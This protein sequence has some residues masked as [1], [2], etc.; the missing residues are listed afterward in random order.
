MEFDYKNIL[1]WGYGKSGRAVENVLKDINVP[2]KIY[3][4][5]IK[6]NGGN[7]I[8]KLSARV[9]KQFD[10]IVLSPAVSIYDKYVKL[11]EQLGV[12]VIGELEFG[13]WFTSADVIAVTGTN[14]KTTTVRLINEALKTAG[15]KSGAYGN[16]GEPLTN[17]YKVD[18]DYI[19]CEVSSFQLETTDR[20]APYVNVLLN[21]DKDHLDRHKTVENYIEIKKSLFK[22]CDNSDCVVLNM[23][24]KN[25]EKISREIAGS[26]TNFNTKNGFEIKNN[27]LYFKGEKTIKINE[28]LLNYT[29]TDNIL[30]VA[31]VLKSLNLDL[32]ILN[33]IELNEPCVPHR[34]EVFKK[35]NGVTYID[36]SKATNPH[37]M[38]KAVET[39]NGN[40]VLLLGGLNKG[41]N[42]NE[43]ISKLPNNV[44]KIITFGKSGKKISKICKKYNIVNYNVKWLH[45]VKNIL[46]NVINIGD[47]VLFSPA[48]ASFD[49]FN[50]YDKRGEYFKKIVNEMVGD[51]E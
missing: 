16:I 11:A 4:K 17:A 32:E 41:F 33:K 46:H 23:A 3:D 34:L 37:A 36:D 1:I 24:D 26:Q 30:A 14:G 9:L 28:R 18:L 31:C 12:K 50:G 49:E 21:V 40:I 38:L 35:F 20:F 10:L 5:K 6:V 45:N 22:N 29:Y 51:N 39:L 42:F 44:T 7:Y 47:T 19:V 2:Y 43:L 48:C 15:Y 25:C 27:T 8:Y 13:F